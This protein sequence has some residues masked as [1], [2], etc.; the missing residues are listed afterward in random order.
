M[1]EQE[2]RLQE[3]GSMS[4]IYHLRQAPGSTPELSLV[5]SAESVAKGHDEGM[6]ARHCHMQHGESS[7]VR[8]QV[9]RCP[10]QTCGNPA[11]A[12]M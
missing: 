6:P 7:E 8:G 9:F 2:G 4:K 1:Q 11:T 5:S 12:S 10:R 3:S